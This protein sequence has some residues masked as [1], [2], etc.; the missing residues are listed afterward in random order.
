MIRII[1]KRDT[2]KTKKLLEECSKEGGIFICKH[3]ERLLDKCFVYDIPISNIIP[4]GYDEVLKLVKR[5]TNKN[6]YIDELEEFLNFL[7]DNKL[8]G[9]SKTI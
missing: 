9:Y 7:F 4:Y 2:G 3:P 8:A 5:K 6:I 1:D